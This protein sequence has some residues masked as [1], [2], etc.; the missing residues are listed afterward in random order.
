MDLIAA[1]PKTSLII[2]SL[3]VTF[4]STLITKYLTDQAHMKSL[5][6]R[7]KALQEEMK[8]HKDHPDKIM[9]LQTEALKITGT[10]M[11]S[12]FKP[13]LVTFIPF[14]ILLYWL[15]AAY[16]P[17]LGNGWIWYYIGVS[18]ASSF[19]FRKILNVN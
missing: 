7:Q 19:G 10:M 6:D 18:I 14:L 4:V 13:L 2:I 3:A 9:E 8:K 17:V 11:K 12:S 16:V 15:R 5:K 1:Y